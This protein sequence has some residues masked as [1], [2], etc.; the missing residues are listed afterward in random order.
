MSE[1]GKQLAKQDEFSCENS[2]LLGSVFSGVPS[3]CKNAYTMT[4]VPGKNSIGVFCYLPTAL[5][6]YHIS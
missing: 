6:S 1:K 3:N 2:K 4:P 5:V